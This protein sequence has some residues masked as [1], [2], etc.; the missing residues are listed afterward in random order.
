[1]PHAYPALNQDQSRW[2][3]E[4]RSRRNHVDPATPYHFLVEDEV[5]ETGEVLRV[6]VIFLTN[7]ECPW[8]CVMCDLWKNTT[9][10]PVPPGSIPHQV[11]FALNQLSS[12]RQIKLYNSG[13]FF[14]RKAIPR[15]DFPAIIDLLRPFER[16]IVECHP[17]LVA[18]DCLAFRDALHPT[19][20]EVA[21][22]LET[23]CPEVL[24]R[25]NKRMT[26]ADYARAAAFLARHK[27]ALRSFVL[28]QPPFMSAKAALYWAERSLDFAFNVGATAVSLIPTR[29]G[30]G[31]LEALAKLGQ[32]S[33][34]SLST[35]E[36]AAE[37]GLSRRRGRVFADL[38]DLE[39]FADCRLCFAPRRERL[40]EMNLRQAVPPRHRCPH[41]AADA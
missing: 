11:R 31:A 20:L 37:Y 36:Q 41:C 33:P 22:G 1:M 26:L 13:S 40:Q 25:L 6:A 27:I 21:M 14:D 4:H 5:A 16:V 32:F 12:V 38:W 23:A 35:L 28:V 15:T 9:A 30:N 24:R 29:P 18:G 39:T 7:R 8:R 19:R 2:I 34:P 10:D 3:L 17:A